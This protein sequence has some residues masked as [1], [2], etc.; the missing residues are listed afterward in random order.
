MSNRW[1]VAV[2]VT[3]AVWCESLWGQSPPAQPRR[4]EG[5]AET[6]RLMFGAGVN[7]EAGVK[8]Q[9]M[10]REDSRVSQ[11]PEILLQLTL[12]EFSP[13]LGDDGPWAKEMTELRESGL[14]ETRS[15]PGGTVQI[16]STP[17]LDK[18]VKS[19]RKSGRGR[20][21]AEPSLVTHSGRPA[22]FQ[23]G[24]Q[25][26]I[27]VPN[28]QAEGYALIAYRD[29]GVKA[30]ATPTYSQDA[31]RV[32]VRLESNDLTSAA[33][34]AVRSRLVQ[35]TV[36]LKEGQSALV[37]GLVQQEEQS[38]KILLATI[39]PTLVA[40]GPA[41]QPVPSS[42]ATRP[43]AAPPK[44][45]ASRPQYESVAAPD[46][47]DAAQEAA[48]RR[49]EAHQLIEELY[50]E[51]RVQMV[52]LPTTVIVRG[53]VAR[54]EHVEQIA[55]IV[56]HYFPGALNHLTLKETAPR[57]P[58]AAEY[59]PPILIPQTAPP[60]ASRPIPMASPNPPAPPKFLEPKTTGAL[61]ELQEEVKLLR[62]DV[63]RLI[64]LLEQQSDSDKG[65]ARLTPDGGSVF[66]PSAAALPRDAIPRSHIY[67]ARSFS[68]FAD[69][70]E[71]AETTAR[72]AEELRA[73]FSQEWLARPLP[74]W[75]SPCRIEVQPAGAA[76]GSTTYRF[77]GGAVTGLHMRL[78]G[79]KEKLPHLLAHEVMHTVLATHFG[80]P[81][82][83]WADE[84]IA[85]AAES[86]EYRQKLSRRLKEAAASG[87]LL[88]LR[89]LLDM[90]EYPQGS[91]GVLTLHAQ[92]LSLVEFFIER[93]GKRKLIQFLEDALENND[94]DAA[95]KTHYDFA[96][97]DVC[98]KAWR[99]HAG[100]G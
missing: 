100:L 11:G 37:T 25:V 6:G 47:E 71:L 41:A 72:T 49:Q 55:E 94:W 3:A 74:K 63:N 45:R 62:R 78:Q 36:E 89:H 4:T 2:I 67:S 97:C 44:A 5:A 14:K 96:A 79:P 82:P 35:T 73:R 28:P 64:D 27:R 87:E 42:E 21:L 80:R 15:T 1:I 24:A 98:E 57:N 31:F 17:E 34:P 85:C 46:R 48:A 39:T 8:G 70:K 26:P 92:G 13:P 66:Q 51:A 88:P 86:A 68:A 60:A 75:S 90:T 95:L 12:I 32:E 61:R 69:G 43:A 99:V 40:V 83:R 18:V 52:R 16:W 59:P 93:G 50:P 19:F 84:G 23:S 91:Q 20:I 56:A 30:I 76:G 38:E 81:L 10:F 65:E 53:T 77:E 33:P 7:S 29:V 9:A 22:T 54:P 58:Q